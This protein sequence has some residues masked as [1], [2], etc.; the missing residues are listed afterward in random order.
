M[1]RMTFVG[2]CDVSRLAEACGC[3]HSVWFSAA[4]W[5]WSCQIKCPDLRKSRAAGLLVCI[6]WE[7]RFSRFDRPTLMRAKGLDQPVWINVT[8]GVGDDGVPHLFVFF[9]RERLGRLD[10]YWPK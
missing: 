5:K 3:E 4:L 7:L 6:G 2:F 8:K 10:P 1:T 9:P